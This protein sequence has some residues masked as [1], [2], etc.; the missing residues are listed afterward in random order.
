[1]LSARVVSVDEDVLVAELLPAGERIVFRGVD[2]E[3]RL[4]RFVDGDDV[5]ILGR[6]QP[7]G[8]TPRLGI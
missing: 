6:D 4:V 5:S 8:R 3:W 2:D 1:M 7:Q